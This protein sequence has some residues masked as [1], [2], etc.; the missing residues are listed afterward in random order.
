MSDVAYKQASTA[1]TVPSS[2]L[3][4]HDQRYFQEVDGIRAIAV[5]MV[6]FCHA[7]LMGFAGGF[8]G[9]D[10]FFVIS[11]LVIYLST[12]DKPV[13]HYPPAAGRQ[14]L[15]RGILCAA[16]AASAAFPVSDGVGDARF[17]PGF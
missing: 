7:K 17:L 1:S 4:S 3:S 13:E 5:L 2:G 14:F 9:V 6:M 16:P 8:V 12:R 10:I 11:G 15:A